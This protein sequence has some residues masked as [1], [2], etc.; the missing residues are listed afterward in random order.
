MP[1]NSHALERLCAHGFGVLAVGLLTPA[2]ESSVEEATTR[3]FDI[4]GLAA[5]AL[6]VVHWVVAQE[7]QVPIGILAKG[8]AVAAALLVAARR[9][10][11]AIVSVAGRPDLAAWALPRV[12]TPTL[13]I[14]SADNVPSLSFSELGAERLYCEHE[15]QAIP[16]GGLLERPAEAEATAGLALRWFERHLLVE[17]AASA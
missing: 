1:S 5:R 6:D 7:L 15:L 9:R 10:L 12:Q 3:R 8:T 13:F 2:E 14:A 11:G 17:E 16:G 4:E